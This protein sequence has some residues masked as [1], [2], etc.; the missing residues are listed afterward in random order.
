MKYTPEQIIKKQSKL[1]SER[2]VL[3]QHLQE[4]ADY[5]LPRKNFFTRINVPGEKKGF[6]L[7]DNTA[8]ISAETL[9]ASLHG[10]LTNPNTF[11]FGL[12]TPFDSLNENEFVMEYLQQLVKTMHRILNGS[13]FQP[14]VYEFYVDLATFGTAAMTAEEDDDL[15]VRFSTV[16]LADIFVCENH[17]GMIDECYRVFMWDARKIVEKFVP[18]ADL[19]DEEKV[20]AVVGEKVFNCYKK[21]DNNRFK[22]IHAVYKDHDSET[23]RL[24]Y[25][26]QYII[27]ET[28]KE[29]QSGK[30]RQFPYIISRWSKISGEVYGRSPG[31]TA[32][33]EAKTLNVMAKTILKGAQKVVDPP[34]QLPD[35]G[36]VR[37]F[38]TA[39]GSVN[40][41]RA[42]SNDIA[43]P[44][45]NDSR[46]DFGYEAMRERQQRVREAFFVD[47]LNLVQSDRMTTVE[48]NQRIQ[49]QLRFLGPLLGRQQTEFLKPLIDRVFDIMV[50]RDAGTGE[51]LGEIPPE[52]QEIDLDVF[53]SSPIARAQRL[54]EVEAIQGAFQASAAIF[55]LD[56]S[57]VDLI[58]SDRWV[59]EHFKIYGA[60]QKVLR[61]NA[62]VE[63]IRDARAE[64]QA[65]AVQ[66]AQQNNSVDNAAKVAPIL[67]QE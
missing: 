39:P 7:Y 44:I 27:E 46:I 35:E 20:K 41:Y 64:A 4:C 28:K 23:P 57:A 43:R 3:D 26:S 18:A 19:G 40:Y 48:V 34:V 55:Q 56:P 6:E 53:Y 65:Q 32:L 13:N 25:L 49:E 51:L 33:P 8:M 12:Q 62:E 14:E 36:F 61:K 10:M 16:H 1:K 2:G 30:F 37:P 47:K 24:P 54:S 9:V 11:W 5:I 60:S 63:A 31:M 59:R 15:V 45:F 50:T 67:A 38:K 21:N 17:L 66:Q 22:V 52:L 42:G 58:D 29:V